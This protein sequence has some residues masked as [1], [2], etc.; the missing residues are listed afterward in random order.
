MNFRLFFSRRFIPRI[1]GLI[2]SFFNPNNS[3]S[4]F[5]LYKPLI[6]TNSYIHW[7]NNVTI[8]HNA[9]IQGVSCYCN[10]KFHQLIIIKDG[11]S[12]QQNCHITCAKNIYIGRD[13][14]I[15]SNVTITDIDHPYSDI[16]TPPEHQPIIVNSVKI[17]DDCK[18]YN[19]SVILPGVSIGKHCVIGANTVV[20]RDIPDFCIAVGSPARIVKRYNPISR[21]WEKTHSNGEFI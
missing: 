12:I 11:V 15:A 19:N 16:N 20:T 9:R 6:F 4:K 2:Y 21:R 10:I 8:M 1:R 3:G 14:A 7:Y 18:I 13:T 17:G 5:V